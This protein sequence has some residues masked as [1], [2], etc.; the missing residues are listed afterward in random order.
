LKSV[1]EAA[2]A[3]IHPTELQTV[4]VGDAALIR[5]PLTELGAGTVQVHEA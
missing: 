1:L 5:Q 2:R 3:H 4:V